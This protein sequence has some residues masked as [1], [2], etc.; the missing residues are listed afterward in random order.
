MGCGGFGVLA[1]L[2]CFLSSLSSLTANE[3]GLKRNVLTGRVNPD[4]V[5]YGGRHLTG[6][7][8]Q[9]LPFPATLE[10]ITYAK[11]GDAL[12]VH[13]RT[14]GDPADPDSG[15]QP[16]IISGSFQFRFVRSLIPKVYLSF[17][18][19][20]QTKL[21]Y[22]LLGRNVM[23]NTAQKFTPQ[24]FWLNRKL[25][26]DR[27]VRELNETI[28]YQGYG[29]VLY[30][31]M[32]RVDFAA[33]YEESIT[34]IQVAEQ[35]RVIREYEQKV[36]AVE[37]HIQVMRA[38]NNATVEKILASGRAN[39]TVVVANATQRAF[40]LKQA[41]KAQGYRQVMDALGLESAEQKRR[42]LELKALSQAPQLTIGLDRACSKK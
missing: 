10:T 6:P 34:S 13:T 28:F 36:A 41:A 3:F 7:L 21:R 26:S 16:I 19:F 8:Y 24:D 27:M 14:G 2:V 4:Y 40:H 23:S 1:L 9:L 31:E 29:E 22:E 42:Y 18:T 39:S 25:I 17:A 12:P 5:Y 15:G 11:Q 38:V 35:L 30:F 37:Q 20:A 33:Q 32:E